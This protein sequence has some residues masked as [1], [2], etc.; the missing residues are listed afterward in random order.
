MRV[1]YAEKW[2]KET[3]KL[4]EIA[5]GCGLTEALKWGKPCFTFQKKNVA[6]VIP[7]KESCAFSFFKGALLKD[8]KH[9]L[10]RIGDHTQAARWIKFTSIKEIAPLRSTLTEYIYEAIALEKAGRKAELKKPSEYPIPEELQTRLDG[11]ATLRAAF[12]ALSPG[13]KKSHIFH[14]ASAKQAKTRS[15]RVERCVPMIL[16][17]RGFNELPD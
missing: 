10:K 7:L 15:A 16:N 14:I 5:A 6:I 8:P 13:R 9:I 1:P 12:T 11:N 17:G 3:D 2:Q 4:R